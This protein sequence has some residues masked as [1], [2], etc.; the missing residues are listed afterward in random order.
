MI[1]VGAGIL[2]RTFLIISCFC[3]SGILLLILFVELCCNLFVLSAVRYGPDA[4]ILVLGLFSYALA[5]LATLAGLV[6]TLAG[7]VDVKSVLVILKSALVFGL[8]VQF[9]A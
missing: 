9:S 5:G 8:N 2:P 3:S 4:A 7:L 6:A 1:R